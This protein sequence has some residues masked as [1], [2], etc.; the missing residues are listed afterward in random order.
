MTPVLVRVHL[1]IDRRR[2]ASWLAAATAAVAVAVAWL[3]M[4]P[5]ADAGLRVAAAV[6]AGAVTAVMAIGDPPRGL[7]GPVG[8]WVW[9]RAAW[10]L[11]A[12]V[13][14]TVA[15][16]AA[17]PVDAGAVVVPSALFCLAVGATAESVRASVWAGVTP[18][19]AVS[20][21]LAVAGAAAAAAMAAAQASG[22]GDVACGAAVLM[23]W[24]ACT[25]ALAGWR[26][27]RGPA[28]WP[29]SVGAAGLFACGPEGRLLAGIAMV[30]TLAGMV[31][32]LFLAADA[33]GWYRL[34]VAGWFTAAAVPQATLAAA[35]VERRGRPAVAWATL[36]GWPLVV[37]AM[38]APNSAVAVDRLVSG[39]G[40]AS[41]AVALSLLTV[42][43]RRAGASQETTLAVGLAVALFAVRWLCS[44]S[45]VHDATVLP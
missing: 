37:A 33:G 13:A 43:F 7:S 36:L 27:Q 22:C 42:G 21:P 39:G 38:L 35:E 5:P 41:A 19:D 26:R 25:A 45:P 32:W 18:A 40:L 9:L 16:V 11:A 20:M 6:V 1:R 2:P 17:G 4:Q 15:C 44:F 30:T 31:G 14:A 23:T 3:M 34:L 12:A 10:P 24:L 28:A 8:A 29:D